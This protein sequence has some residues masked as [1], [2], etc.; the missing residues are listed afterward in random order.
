MTGVVKYLKK[1]CYWQAI[2]HKLMNKNPSPWVANIKDVNPSKVPQCAVADGVWL[3]RV[4]V[5]NCSDF[6][7]D[8][9]V[10]Y[11]QN[12]DSKTLLSFSLMESVVMMLQ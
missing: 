2:I 1:I 8:P 6:P 5:P 7:R 10:L 12:A 11:E 4:S 9:S 3:A